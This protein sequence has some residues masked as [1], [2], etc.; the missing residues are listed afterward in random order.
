[1]PTAAK[2]PVGTPSQRS[3]RKGKTAPSDPL[4]SCRLN[5]RSGTFL[6]I[7]MNCRIG[8]LGPASTYV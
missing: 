2:Y 8:S 6:R 3:G 4:Q 5:G 1:M 7:R